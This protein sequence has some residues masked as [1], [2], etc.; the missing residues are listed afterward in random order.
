MQ[1]EIFR[2]YLESRGTKESTIDEY[3]ICVR[4]IDDFL[5]NE[6]SSLGID[7]SYLKDFQAFL[8]QWKTDKKEK[9]AFL[10]A[11]KS[12]GL[13]TDNRNMIVHVTR[14]L[15]KGPWLDR[16]EETLDEFVGEELRRKIIGAGGPIKQSASTTKKA[17]WTKC[18]MDCLEA[19][20]DEKTCKKILTNN[21]HFKSPKSPSFKKLK[22]LY[23]KTGNIDNV[24]ER[25][26]EKW[27][28]RIGDRYGYDSP[29]YR[30]VEADPTIEAGKREGNIVYVSKIPYQIEEFLEAKD[31]KTKRYHYCHCGWVRDS[32]KKSGKEQVSPT[33]C[34]C[35]GGWHKVPFEGIFGQVLEVDPVKSVLKGD[36][37]C[38]F[39][40]HLPKEA[41]DD[42]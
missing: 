27:K 2:R 42:E 14:L 4:R 6:K 29:E 40:I 34:L 10:H 13:A 24:L 26:H 7:K 9:Q 38:T 41:I 17:V 18:M 32:L 21:L 5:L 19:N 37:L 8:K 16:F 15:G 12:Y 35:S 36:D 1:E 3:V 20:A 30:Y 23:E 28:K 39:A 31:E 22:R 33:F 25:L 11:L